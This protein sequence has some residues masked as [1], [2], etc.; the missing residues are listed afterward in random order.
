[1]RCALHP[2]LPRARMAERGE[3]GNWA[4]FCSRRRRRRGHSRK[5]PLLIAEPD[6]AGHEALPVR[7]SPTRCASSCPW[8][9]NRRAGAALFQTS[10]VSRGS[11]GLVRP[12]SSLG[13]GPPRLPRRQGFRASRPRA[14]CRASR[15]PRPSRSGGRRGHHP[16]RPNH[17]AP[18]EVQSSQLK[19]R[20]SPRPGVGLPNAVVG[21][22]RHAFQKGRSP[23]APGEAD[24]SRERRFVHCPLSK[25]RHKGSGRGRRDFPPPEVMCQWGA[26][27]RFRLFLQCRS[28]FRGSAIACCGALRGPGGGWRVLREKIERKKERHAIPGHSRFENSC[29]PSGLTSWTASGKS[30]PRDPLEKGRKC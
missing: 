9:T 28:V 1:M 19:P 21:F 22:R 5:G 17:G 6:E 13:R 14:V 16:A 25:H 29:G 24:F 15:P 8:R 30:D 10:G 2:R 11:A 12:A 23:P 26:S 27:F 4:C 3:R 7:T 18:A 20:P